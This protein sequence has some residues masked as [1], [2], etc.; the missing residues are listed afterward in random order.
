MYSLFLC[1]PARTQLFQRSQSKE[2]HVASRLMNL[3]GERTGW[4]SGK[5]GKRGL[6]EVAG[7]RGPIG[8]TLVDL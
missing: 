4:C 6:V 5:R 2:W 8:S 3:K 7:G 1:T